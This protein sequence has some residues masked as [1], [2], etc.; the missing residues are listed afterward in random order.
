MM[1]YESQS[2]GAQRSKFDGSSGHAGAM[3]SC[4]A[5]SELRAFAPGDAAAAPSPFALRRRRPGTVVWPRPRLE[6]HARQSRRDLGCDGR[7]ISGPFLSTPKRVGG[8]DGSGSVEAGPDPAARP[9]FPC[10]ECPGCRHSTQKQYSHRSYRQT[11]GHLTST[12]GNSG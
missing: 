2:L 12:A 8:G 3:A 5:V 6:A 10:A 1:P 7:K 4:P 9:T 11:R